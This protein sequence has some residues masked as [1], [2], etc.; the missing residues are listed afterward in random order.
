MSRSTQAY[1]LTHGLLCVVMELHGVA[2][3]PITHV[4]HSLAARAGTGKATNHKL[5]P[6]RS[7]HVITIGQKMVEDKMTE[8]GA[9][10]WLS[11]K[12]IKR[13]GFFGGDVTLPKLLAHT[14]LHE[15]AHALQTVRGERLRGSV[16]NPEFYRILFQL[17]KDHGPMVLASVERVFKQRGIDTAFRSAPA[18][19]ETPPQA[20]QSASPFAARIHDRRYSPGDTVCFEHKGETI[21]A[22]VTKVNQKTISFESGN[23]K[24]RIHPALLRKA[25]PAESAP[26]PKPTPRPSFRVRQKVWFRYKGRPIRGEVIRCNQE[27]VSV[28]AD[29]DGGRWRVSYNFLHAA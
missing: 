15:Y 7:S 19:T 12:E 14:V 28:K 22:R 13:Y 21:T 2:G 23:L 6:R 26:G 3:N 17:H 1:S 29:C 4:G 8:A 9:S 20:H 27:T 11:T 24:G 16:H 5:Y 18:L 10:R 25:D